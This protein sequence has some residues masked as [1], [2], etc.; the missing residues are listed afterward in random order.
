MIDDKLDFLT[1]PPEP[2]PVDQR[3]DDVPLVAVSS[4]KANT[5]EKGQALD[6][7]ERERAAA[8]AQIEEELRSATSTQL[9]RLRA[10]LAGELQAHDAEAI[11]QML[12]R[13]TRLVLRLLTLNQV[14]LPPT[15]SERRVH[16]ARHALNLVDTEIQRRAD[17]EV[18]HPAVSQPPRM[19]PAVEKF[20]I[21]RAHDPRRPPLD[22]DEV[23]RKQDAERERNRK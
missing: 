19:Q 16:I 18:R 1:P 23:A 5:A 21:V 11:E 20:Q 22:R 2:R 3:L 6:R 8:N 4:S 14:V 12:A 10:A 7:I 13:F 15:E 9:K 17:V